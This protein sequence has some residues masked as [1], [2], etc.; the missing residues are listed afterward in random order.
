MKKR[1]D[2]ALLRQVV[3]FF[4][5]IGTFPCI[6]KY[7]KLILILII[8]YHIV[9]I[10]CLYNIFSDFFSRFDLVSIGF[11]IHAGT[12]SAIVAFNLLCWKDVQRNNGVLWKDFFKY[13][14]AFD[15]AME[16]QRANVETVYKYYSRIVLMNICYVIIYVLIYF[17]TIIQFDSQRVIGLTYIYFV[18]SQILVTTIVLENI[19]KMIEKRYELFKWKIREVY[20]SVNTVRKFWDGQQLKALYLVLNNMVKKINVLFGQRILVLL[21]LTFLDVL[22]VFQYLVLEFPHQKYKNFMYLCSTC[23]QTLFFLVSILKYLDT[24]V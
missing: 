11:F 18:S 8:P 23:A 2:V 10:L 22:G 19:F 16:G 20:L 1:S 6:Q 15:L 7:I 9:G 4:S 13:V 17:S 3:R 14:E 12:V 5:F 24:P 21:I